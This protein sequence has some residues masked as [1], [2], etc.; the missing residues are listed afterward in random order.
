MADLH[1]TGW[2]PPFLNRL[3]KISPQQVNAM[4]I[5]LLVL[6]CLMDH[7]RIFIRRIERPAVTP[8]HMERSLGAVEIAPNTRLAGQRTSEPT[9]LPYRSE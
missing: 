1:V 3:N 8:T 6:C 4:A 5:G 7:L 2:P 9:M